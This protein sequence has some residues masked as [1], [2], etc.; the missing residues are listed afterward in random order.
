MLVYTSFTLIWYATW[1]LSEKKKKKL[2][3][4]PTPGVEGV[5]KDL[6]FAYMVLYAEFPLIWYET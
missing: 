4:D 1:S 5:C 2:T 6:I 3:F